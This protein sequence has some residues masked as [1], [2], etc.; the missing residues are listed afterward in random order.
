MTFVIDMSGS[1][2]RADYT[3]A[4]AF[5]AEIATSFRLG[6]SATRVA[7]ITY[8]TSPVLNFGFNTSQNSSRISTAINSAPY[9][10]RGTGTASALYLMIRG[11][12]GL[13]NTKPTMAPTTR[14]TT[15]T[16]TAPAITTRRSGGAIPD[17]L[18]GGG[19]SDL[20]IPLDPTTT[21][22]PTVPPTIAPQEIRTRVGIVITDGKSNDNVVPASNLAHDLGITLFAVGVGNSDPSELRTIASDPDGAHLYYVGDYTVIENIRTS[23][24]QRSCLGE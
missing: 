18:G 14:P 15:Q 17:G 5:A 6:Q 16:S 19:G 3:R 13:N 21:P 9:V 7:L 24:R 23:V 12:Y 10:G 8:S 11:V 22:P 20:D 2:A 4:K 1:V